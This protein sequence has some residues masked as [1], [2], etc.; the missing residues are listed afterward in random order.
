MHIYIYI[1]FLYILRDN[2]DDFFLIGRIYLKKNFFKHTQN[3]MLKFQIEVILSIHG[4]LKLL[5]N[6]Y[7]F[8]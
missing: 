1:H 8:C 3:N 7:L 6:C 5:S 2:Y 4:D